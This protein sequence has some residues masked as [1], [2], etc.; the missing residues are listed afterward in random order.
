MRKVALALN[1]EI[2]AQQA[3]RVA[4][5]TLLKH[6]AAESIAGAKSSA[7]DCHVTDRITALSGGRY[8]RYPLSAPK[9]TRS[10]PG[11]CSAIVTATCGPRPFACLPSWR[12]PLLR[13]QRARLSA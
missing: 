8:S 9:L 7:G 6:W 2:S 10:C 12:Y 1:Q 5:A 13:R 11:I 3:E 4:R